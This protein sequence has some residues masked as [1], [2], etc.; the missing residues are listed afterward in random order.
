M[1]PDFRSKTLDKE[2][3]TDFVQYVETLTRLSKKNGLSLGRLNRQELAV[4]LLYV[5]TALT[6]G[7]R[8]DE[9]QATAA[10]DHWKV[11]FA[12]ML[13]SD[14]VELRRT[15]I[16]AHYWVRDPHGRGYEIAPA[17]AGNALFI[18]LVKERIETRIAEQLLYAARAREERKKAALQG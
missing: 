2:L 7:E 4:L 14:V 9:R 13:R 1:L 3:P 11:Q 6:P 16:D 15:L 18:R 5:S 10:L 17:I 12:P 8:Y